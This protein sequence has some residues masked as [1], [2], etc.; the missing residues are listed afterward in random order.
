ML[1]SGQTE[2]SDECLR[3][4][5]MYVWTCILLGGVGSEDGEWTVT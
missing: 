5:Y 4:I 2:L 3:C 1:Q